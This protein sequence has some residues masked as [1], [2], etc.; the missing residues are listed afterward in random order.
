M[1]KEMEAFN[2]PR[3]SKEFKDHKD[4]FKKYSEGVKKVWHM[5]QKIVTDDV[6]IRY[7]RTIEIKMPLYWLNAD[8]EP[9]MAQKNEVIEL[10]KEEE[11]EM[12]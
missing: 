7:I 9:R 8:R 1:L 11:E 2:A 12:E 6:K 5:Q 10:D 3:D 4:L